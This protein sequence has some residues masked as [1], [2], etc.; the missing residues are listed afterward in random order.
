LNKLVIAAIIGMLFLTACEVGT[1]NDVKVLAPANIEVSANITT[2]DE[3][4][5]MEMIDRG[6]TKI[7]RYEVYSELYDFAKENFC[8]RKFEVLESKEIDDYESMS[9]HKDAAIKNCRAIVIENPGIDIKIESSGKY[10]E[11]ISAPIM[12]L[13][14][15]AEKH[16]TYQLYTEKMIIDIKVDI[17][18][19]KGFEGVFNTNTEVSKVL[20]LDE[21]EE[22]INEKKP[23]YWDY[24]WKNLDIEDMYANEGVRLEKMQMNLDNNGKAYKVLALYHYDFA[25]RLLFF[26][27]DKYIDY[28]DFG[29]KMAGT[30]YRLEKAGD[31]VFIVGKSCRGYGTG[32]GRY[33]EDWYT[34][35]DKGKK[36][37]VSLP[38]DDYVGSPVGGYDLK[39]KSIKLNTN[40]EISLTADYDLKKFYYMR[41]DIGDD[42]YGVS[43]EVQKKVIF[44]WDN[45]KAAFVSE[46][47]PNDM[48]M[49]E[50]PPEGKDIAEKCTYKLKNKYQILT[51]AILLLD[52]E[53]DTYEKENMKSAWK[54]FL[55]DC[56]DCDEKAVL[57][58]MLKKK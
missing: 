56:E 49:T 36:L 11:L 28:I 3:I 53:T 2:P 16:G 42:I 40:G 12:L 34:L 17:D 13:V 33:F 43:V 27:E 6:K 29:G 20:T 46:F 24:I 25:L 44:K 32:M 47:A 54:L 52:E 57:F 22:L 14:E 50:I 5:S 10:D 1:N 23:Y 8:G 38:Y 7:N 19:V 26:K 9:Q 37:V 18:F 39:A 51:E 45:E 30:E 15:H 31:K 48:G 4:S 55:N 41:T 58:E 35:T 21:I